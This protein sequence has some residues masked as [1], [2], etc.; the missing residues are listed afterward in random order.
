MSFLE[1]CDT[2]GCQNW[3]LTDGRS[4]ASM[5]RKKVELAS[6][7]CAEN[8]DGGR[9]VGTPS[10]AVDEVPA[11]GLEQSHDPRLLA[12]IDLNSR[13]GDRDL[14][15][16]TDGLADTLAHP[17]SIRVPSLQAPQYLLPS[18]RNGRAEF[19]KGVGSIEQVAASDREWRAEERQTSRRACLPQMHC[20]EGSQ[21]SAHAITLTPA[22]RAISTAPLGDNS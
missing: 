17:G 15:R 9:P 11:K 14:F 13:A 12:H 21:S 4:L 22:K 7:E 1:G 5:L 19:P 3:N 20:D 2:G 8:M 18:P 6:A 16:L 10:R